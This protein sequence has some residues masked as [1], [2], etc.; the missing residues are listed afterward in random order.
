MLELV[1]LVFKVRISIYTITEDLYLTNMIINNRFEKTI[2]LFK[3]GAHFDV[4]YDK[5]K[6]EAIKISQSLISEVK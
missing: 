1:S 5:Q 6:A 4:L 3:S 2:S